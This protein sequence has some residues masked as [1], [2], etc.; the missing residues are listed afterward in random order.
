MTVQE[1]QRGVID[2]VLG[3]AI[4]ETAANKWTFPAQRTD[5]SSTAPDAIPEG[6]MFRL[7]ATLDRDRMRMDSY[8]RMIARAVQKHGMIVWDTS[9]GVGFRAENPAGNYPLSANPYYRAGGSLRCPPHTNPDN[10][11]AQCAS[12][13][14]LASFPWDKLQAILPP[15][16]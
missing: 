8:A 2:H 4:P 13:N 12:S 11:P 7:P 5:G 9:G 6:T 15:R 16:R 14:R 1:Q 3:L 10:P